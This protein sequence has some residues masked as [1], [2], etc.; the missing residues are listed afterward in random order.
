MELRI[1]V[2]GCPV[3][4]AEQGPL[5]LYALIEC[6][7]APPC[8][9]DREIV[10]L[11]RAYFEGVIDPLRLDPS[12]AGPLLAALYGGAVLLYTSPRGTVPLG[13]T[14]VPPGEGLRVELLEGPP[15]ASPDPL[16][17]WAG[18]VLDSMLPEYSLD[19]PLRLE[20][21]GPCKLAPTGF[22]VEAHN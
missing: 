21:G 15:P 2:T 9:V 17:A 19:P 14:Q 13:R 20:K 12:R 8:S 5:R 4:L 16:E 22:T 10:E 18:I 7:G 3:L 11:A 6:N 1:E